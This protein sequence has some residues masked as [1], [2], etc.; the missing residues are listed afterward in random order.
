[1]LMSGFERWLGQVAKK[2]LKREGAFVVAVTGSMGKSTTKQA[3]G[4]VL[5]SDVWGNRVR[6]PK[7]SFNNALGLP[8]TV[9][10]H[11]APGRNP[12]AWV[13]LMMDAFRYRLGWKRTGMR[14]F[15]LE[16]GADRPGDI[17]YLTSIAPPDISV[18]TAIT[19]DDPTL[20]PVHAANYPSIDDLVKEKSK[21]ITNLKPGGLAV[22]NA[23]DKRVFAMRHLT[24]EKSMTFGEADGT[25]A[26]I[27]SAKITT[28]MTPYGNAP[29][30]LEIK[31]EMYQRAYHVTLPGVFGRSAAY[32]FAAAVCV[33]EAMD[34]APEQIAD[35]P[36]HFKPVNGRT[37]I[38]P[39]IKHT[40]LFDDTYNASPSAV[41]QALRDLASVETAPGQRKIACL[42]EMRELG[43]KSKE[44]HYRVG[45]EAA[46]L[47]ID[48]LVCCGIFGRA[49]LQ[50][51]LDGGLTEDRAFF[52]E[53]TPE[54]GLYIQDI[55]Q[56]GDIVL[57]KASQGTLETKGVRME[58]VIKELMAEPARAE[59]LLVRQA[60]AWTRK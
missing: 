13:S 50:G 25:D 12:F 15:V 39:G 54:A 21:L 45:A 42:G 29:V 30:G 47:G 14:T 26:R 16:M 1:M 4:A 43:E 58:R 44:M 53:D 3:I 20:V 51:A 24:A 41:I 22:L 32:A 46:K 23:D 56:P 37:R 28:V 40:Y 49:M 2:I 11:P 8:L 19:S 38:L 48:V 35:F 6:V 33:G 55:L 34:I 18:V 17:A 60:A 9:L 31:L 10:N 36:K 52:I 59:E 57:A 5:Q 7:A 27:V